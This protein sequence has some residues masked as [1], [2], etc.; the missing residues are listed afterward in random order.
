MKSCFLSTLVALAMSF[1][2]SGA[3]LRDAASYKAAPGDVAVAQPVA[4]AS[5]VA[6]VAALNFQREVA[7]AG[8]A[9]VANRV[10]RVHVAKASLPQTAGAAGNVNVDPDVWSSVAG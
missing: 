4:G 7:T 10:A 9:R 3:V 1:A 2:A 5:R 8:P 6:G